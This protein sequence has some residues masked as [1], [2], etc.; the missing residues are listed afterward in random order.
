M[1]LVD[2]AP[3]V[4]KRSKVK[5]SD[6]LRKLLEHPRVVE[7]AKKLR[8]AK[9]V[10]IQPPTPS[11]N[12]DVEPS[13]ETHPADSRFV[14]VFQKE[15]ATVD[16]ATVQLVGT[17][18]VTTCIGL[19]IWNPATGMTSVGHFDRAEY[20][21][22]GVEQVIASHG[23]S[24]PTVFQVHL[25]GGYDETRDLYES[26]F[27][28]S[29]GDE[30]QSRY[31]LPLSLKIIQTLQKSK[32]MFE[33]GYLC[34][35]QHNTIMG[36]NEYACPAVRG[37]VVETKTGV[38]RP[39]SFQGGA[40]GPDATVR[41]VCTT[42]VTSDPSWDTSLLSPYQTLS[43]SYIIK[44]SKW[45]RV[46]ETYAPYMLSLNDEEFLQT[47]STSPY[48]E[49]PD[50]LGN[51]RRVFNYMLKSPDWRQTFPNGKPRVFTRAEEGGWVQLTS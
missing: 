25:V 13:E 28:D 20:A 16:P 39:A 27:R 43:D 36:S 5:A 21:A 45:S 47:F 29:Q 14:Y 2:G 30:L 22:K 10:V 49:G 46:Y 1:I 24:N 50:F 18:E 26:E 41:L 42:T 35:L 8:A 6:V 44:P 12:S 40:R 31:S 19:A 23:V 3:V 11:G 4:D 17:D 34:I 32:H 37:L 15:Y 48:A 51:C 9:V 33:M 7:S 38:V